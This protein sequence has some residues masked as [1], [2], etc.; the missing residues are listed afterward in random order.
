MKAG[1]FILV[2]S[3]L[4]LFETMALVNTG[5]REGQ[6]KKKGRKFL[7]IIDKYPKGES[8]RGNKYNNISKSLN[9]SFSKHEP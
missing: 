7:R 1:Y 9:L 6:G 5:L 4:Q 2:Q 8:M 3:Y